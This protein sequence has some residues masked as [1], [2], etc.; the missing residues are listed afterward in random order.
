MSE[1]QVIVNGVTQYSGYDWA[2]ASGAFEEYAQEVRRGS[3][4]VTLLQDGEEIKTV[5]A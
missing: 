2:T 3:G 1:W 5:G 4:Y